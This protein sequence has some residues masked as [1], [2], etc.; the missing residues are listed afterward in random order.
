MK[1]SQIYQIM[2][3][4]FFVLILI[5]IVSVM[6]SNSEIIEP[7]TFSK[8]S[9]TFPSSQTN[10]IVLGDID[11]DGDYDAV[12]SNQGENHSQ[13]LFNDGSGYFTDS[14]Q[15][16]TRQGHGVE[17]GD[18]DS[19]GDLDIFIT[20]AGYRD[21][22]KPSKIYFNDGKGNFAVSGQDLGD[23]LQ[24]GNG[25]NLVDIDNDGD[26]DC[27]IFYYSYEILPY[28]HKIYI[29]DG[30]GNFGT[31]DIELPDG[32][33]PFW[34]D[35]NNDGFKDVFLLEW[36]KGLRVMLNNGKSGFSEHWHLRD[37]TIEYGNAGIGDFD[38]DGDMDV[39]VANGGSQ[40]VDS[41]RVFFNDG[42]G[43]LTDSGLKFNSTKWAGIT[44]GDL[45]DDGWIDVFISN[46]NRASEIWLND[47][48]GSF[49]DTGIRIGE[50][51]P[52]AGGAVC[53]I[54]G[55]GDLDLL[56]S[57]YGQKDGSNSVWFNQKK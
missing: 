35:M 37:T 26:L 39:I 15:K 6:C 29:N 56:N 41:T 30:R 27:H 3:R 57:F 25:V 8:S 7:V 2:T 9:Q 32:T 51:Q 44:L 31:S 46:F 48:K 11:G 22:K 23:S 13:I 34:G 19:D 36:G 54:D 16:L 38:N 40:I 42:T 1:K 50:K 24:S 10:D 55:D 52:N 4:T 20:C 14:G 45:N 21:N 47:H 5:G 33:Y 18:L 53:D 49:I 12:F 17:T 28:F 43:K